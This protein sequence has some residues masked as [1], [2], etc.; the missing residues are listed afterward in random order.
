[1]MNHRGEILGEDRKWRLLPEYAENPPDLETAHR[2]N[3]KILPLEERAALP[4]LEV[5]LPGR[6]LEMPSSTASGIKALKS[7]DSDQERSR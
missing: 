6:T 5:D 3:L 7:V 4:S 1:M 2:H